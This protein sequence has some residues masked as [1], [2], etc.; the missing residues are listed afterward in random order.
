MIARQRD[1]SNASCGG[2]NV[3]MT[4]AVRLSSTC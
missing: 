4:T 2:V 3:S 1:Q